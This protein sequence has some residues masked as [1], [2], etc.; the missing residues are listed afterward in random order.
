MDLW[1]AISQKLLSKGEKMNIDSW[2]I[3]AGI[4]AFALIIVFS[5]ITWV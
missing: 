3:I 4:L 1:S 5:V 2:L